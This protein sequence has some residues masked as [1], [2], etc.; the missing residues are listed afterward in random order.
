MEIRQ[1]IS[2]PPK[3]IDPELARWLFDNLNRM[4]QEIYTIRQFLEPAVRNNNNTPNMT[5]EPL[6]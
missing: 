4:Q 2:N 6:T 1:T 3:S 5:F